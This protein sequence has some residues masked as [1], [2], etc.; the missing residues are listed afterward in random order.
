MKIQNAWA[1]VV[2]RRAIRTSALLVLIQEFGSLKYITSYKIKLHDNSSTSSWIRTVGD[3]VCVLFVGLVGRR[4]ILNLSMIGT[5]LCLISL[6][7]MCWWC[8]GCLNILEA[9]LFELHNLFFYIGF[10]G[11]PRVITA[12][13]YGTSSR[14]LGA[15]STAMYH[16]L[17]NSLSTLAFKRLKKYDKCSTLKVLAV[18]SIFYFLIIRAFVLTRN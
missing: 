2:S 1:D 5:T 16:W 3:L 8:K 6:S 12:D 14:D 10:D 15:T 4:F 11:L 13:V 18:L 9:T 7:C 17:M